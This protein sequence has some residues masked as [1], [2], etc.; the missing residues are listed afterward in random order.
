MKTEIFIILESYLPYNSEYSDQDI[1]QVHSVYSEE[2][3]AISKVKELEEIA[4]NKQMYGTG[5]TF[6]YEIIK[7]EIINR[8][9]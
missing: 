1:I 2:S 6:N 9:E 8:T 3:K 5:N 4:Y 7:K